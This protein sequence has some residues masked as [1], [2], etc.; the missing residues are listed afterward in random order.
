[1]PSSRIWRRVALGKT[2]V[3]VEIIATIF[4]MKKSASYQQR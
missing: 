3:S 2:K 1:M 4:K